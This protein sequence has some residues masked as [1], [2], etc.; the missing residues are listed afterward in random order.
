LG[1]PIQHISIQPTYDISIGIPMFRLTFEG[2]EVQQDDFLNFVINH[3]LDWSHN[4]E[5][6]TYFKIDGI[7]Y[8]VHFKEV[9]KENGNTQKLF[10]VRGSYSSVMSFFKRTDFAHRAILIRLRKTDFEELIR[11]RTVKNKI[12]LQIT[13][14]I[15][16]EQIQ[17]SN[18]TYYLQKC[19]RYADTFMK[20]QN[21]DSDILLSDNQVSLILSGNRFTERIIL[22]LPLEKSSSN[23]DLASAIENLHLASQGYTEG[24]YEKVLINTRNAIYNDLT[25][26]MTKGSKNQERILKESIRI[27]CLDKCPDSDKRIYDDVLKETG[28]IAA[29]LARI[30]SK[31]IHKDQDIVIKAP[32][33]NDLE[34]IHFSLSLVIRYLSKL[35]MY[36]R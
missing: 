2:V 32:F 3:K 20:T 29:S 17:L 5:E 14:K 8:D 6:E 22:E 16:Y 10:T 36:Y 25:E 34:L 35:T 21:N 26:L 19:E 31:F 23:S 7:E 9:L 18:G 24:N 11:S 1:L 15:D 4:I 27:A 12:F 28:K 13:C 33:W 30:L